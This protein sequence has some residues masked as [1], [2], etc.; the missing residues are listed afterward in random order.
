MQAHHS[1]RILQFGRYPLLKTSKGK[2]HAVLSLG[3]HLPRCLTHVLFH[4]RMFE[5]SEFNQDISGWNTESATTMRNMFEGSIF[6]QDIS[7]WITSSVTDMHDMF[8][9][10]Q[11]NQDI[12]DWD[13]SSVTDFSS[14]FQ[15]S[16]FNSEIG[17]WNIESAIYLDNM[18]QDSPFNQDI[19]SWDVLLVE[20]FHDMFKGSS[21]NQDISEWFPAVATDM[22]EMFEDATDFNQDL[23]AWSGFLVSR[24]VNVT[25]MFDGTACPDTSDP[26]TAADPVTPLCYVCN[27]GMCIFCPGC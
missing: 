11:F 12:A 22:G 1:I 13:V 27:P 15:N 19:G 24:D 5:N 23:C 3:T 4:C 26:D 8:M 7:S 18:F 9:D 10:S 14:M 2:S 17:I 25:M 21:F 20:D 16:M 6:D